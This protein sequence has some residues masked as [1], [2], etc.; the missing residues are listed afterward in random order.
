MLAHN[1]N[2]QCDVWSMGIIMYLLLKGQFPFFSNCEKDL[3]KSIR[4][5]EPSFDGINLNSEGFHLL[6]KMLAKDPIFRIAP[7]EIEQH[8]WILNRRMSQV[9]HDTNIL[10]MM[11]TWKN[12]MMVCFT[13]LRC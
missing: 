5:K 9:Y 1:Y 6:T 13:F 11:K 8:P 4:K 3:M 10:D 7:S 2:Q 12:E